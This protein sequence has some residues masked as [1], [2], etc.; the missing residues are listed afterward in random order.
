MLGFRV[1]ITRLGYE[2]DKNNN[3]T[4]L[5]EVIDGVAYRTSFH[6][7]KDYAVKSITINSGAI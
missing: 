5:R 4:G 3:A 6:Y 2:Y 7:Y 1:V